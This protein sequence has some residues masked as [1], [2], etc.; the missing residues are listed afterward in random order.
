MKLL[1]HMN[2]LIERAPGHHVAAQVPSYE[3]PVLCAL[4]NKGDDEDGEGVFVT[5]SSEPVMLQVQDKDPDA[6]NYWTH[7]IAWSRLLGKY[8]S[9]EGH[10]ALMSV[11]KG[12]NQFARE[13]GQL[14]D[15]PSGKQA[16]PQSRKKK[17]EAVIAAA[18]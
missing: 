7:E 16:T 11:Y 4:H 10:A 1:E 13:V 9:R 6:G 5:E 12:P 2:L 18:A 15:A 14:K 17:N 3:Y 8:K